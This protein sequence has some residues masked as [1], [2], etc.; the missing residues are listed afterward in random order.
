MKNVEE[1]ARGDGSKTP[2]EVRGSTVRRFYDGMVEEGIHRAYVVYADGNFVSSHARLTE[3]VRSFLASS[4]DFAG[5]EA[6]F[7]GREPGLG[8]LFFAFIHSTGRGLAQGG[9]RFKKYAGLTELLADGLRLAQGMSRKSALAGL[10]WGGGKGIIS[11]PFD[12]DDAAELDSSLRRSYFEAYG[13]FIASLG[14]VYYTAEDAG[15]TKEDMAAVL[16][17]NRY[18]TCIPERLGGSG[19]PSPYTALGVVRAMQAAWGVMRGSEQLSGLKV[20]VQGV[21]NVGEALVRLLSQA[22]AR[23]LMADVADPA[24]RLRLERLRAEVAN[25]ECVDDPD[26]IYDAEVDVFAPCLTQGAIINRETIPRLRAALVC[27][28]TNNILAEPLQDAKLLAERGIAFVPDYVCGRMGIINCADEWMGYL[29]EDTLHAVEGVYQATKQVFDL[30]RHHG[31]TTTEA[32]HQLADEAL[33]EGHPLPRL[34]GRGQRI[35]KHLIET[36]WTETG[37]PTHV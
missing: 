14:G 18:T 2:G 11:V 8:T 6:V 16:S 13:R 17:Q 10:W 1:D 37:H 15:T 26:S 22:G 4:P 24:I 19:N 20:A 34:R 21:G 35:I 5:H 23:V 31:V 7:I 33:R 30:A 9:L 28:A 32:A 27:G 29:E 12:V 3:G 36:G 25:V